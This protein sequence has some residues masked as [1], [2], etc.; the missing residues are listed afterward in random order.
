MRF[1]HECGRRMTNYGQNG[2]CCS[3]C[4][5][6]PDDCRCLPVDYIEPGSMAFRG[7]W[8]HDGL[9]ERQVVKAGKP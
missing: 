7:K 2:C 3:G 8:D 6:Y 5:S 4:H 1:C 9:I